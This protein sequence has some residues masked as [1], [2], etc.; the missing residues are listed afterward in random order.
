M[1]HNCD[2]HNTYIMQHATL[3]PFTWKIISKCDKI[4]FTVVGYLVRHNVE[5]TRFNIPA[6]ITT[7]ATLAAMERRWIFWNRD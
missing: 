3:L 2:S 5:K 7:H 1:I 4:A 6:Q